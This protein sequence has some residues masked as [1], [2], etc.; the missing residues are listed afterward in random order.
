MKR[1]KLRILLPIAIIS[2]IVAGCFGSDDLTL[3]DSDYEVALS[4]GL[5]SEFSDGNEEFSEI[6]SDELSDS[7]TEGQ[8][9]TLP[10]DNSDTEE[11]EVEPENPPVAPSLPIYSQTTFS[12]TDINGDTLSLEDFSDKKLIMV[13]FWEPWCGPCVGEMPDLQS[14]YDI[15]KDKGFVILGV[16]ASTYMH[17]DAVYLLDEL[18][19]TYPIL[20]DDGDL[21]DYRTSYVPTTIFMDGQGNVYT[22]EP[23]IGA[24]SYSKWEYNIKKYLGE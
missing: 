24:N 16:Y 13:N 8:S 3:D 23:I 17:D 10:E 5:N 7:F 21:D 6:E 22:A 1:K 12:M 2:L 15:Y 11:P 18:G 9:E 4:D 14:L 20:E 19:I